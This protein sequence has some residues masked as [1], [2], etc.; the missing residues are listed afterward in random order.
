[1]AGSAP[2]CVSKATRIRDRIQALVLTSCSVLRRSSA[3]A[4]SSSRRTLRISTPGS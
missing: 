3:T 4:R 2:P 1:M